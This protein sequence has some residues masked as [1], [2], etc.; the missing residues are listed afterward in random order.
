M[1]I[2]AYYRKHLID[3][4]FIVYNLCSSVPCLRLGRGPQPTSPAARRPHCA[5]AAL[6]DVL[7][8]SYSPANVPHHIR[9]CSCQ[10][11]CCRHTRVRRNLCKK[12]QKGSKEG[13]N[14]KVEATAQSVS[15][16][17]PAHGRIRRPM[18]RALQAPNSAGSRASS[19]A[20]FRQISTL[21]Q[22]GKMSHGRRFICT[23]LKSTFK[24][25]SY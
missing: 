18:P 17:L 7:L 24:T 20:R 6:P 21:L 16:L 1:S 5:S 12:E 25:L 11:A 3:Y 23:E 4:K 22:G 15:V 8:L 19:S 10:F 9:H 13:R 2:I 14:K